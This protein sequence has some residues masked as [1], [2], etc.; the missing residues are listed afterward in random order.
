[1]QKR[2]YFEID[3]PRARLLGDLREIQEKER[4]ISDAQV[5]ALAEKYGVSRVEIEGVCTFYHFLTRKPA[6]KHTIYLNDAIISRMKG[7]DRIQ[8]A[9]EKETGARLGTTDPT[10]TFGFYSTACIGLS[11][12]EPA[13]LI[14][15]QPFTHLNVLRVREIVSQ[16]RAGIPA[17]ELCDS[18]DENVR[19]TPPGGTI[20]FAPW[21][22]GAAIR[23]LSTITRDFALEKI[24][25]SGLSGRGGAFFPTWKKW[26]ACRNYKQ[27]PRF[28]ICNADEGEPGTFK[29]RVLLQNAPGT[30]IEGMIIAAYITRASWGMIYLRGEYSW[31]AEKIQAE[32]ETF[33]NEGLL[34]REIAGMRDFSFDIRLEIGAGAYVCGE[35]TALLESMEGFRG[36]PRTKWFYPV[37]RG[38]LQ[39]PT[40]VN[41]V[42]TFAA[43]SR[44]LGLG[45]TNWLSH[46]T[47]ESRGTKLISVSGDCDLPGIYEVDYGMKV[48]E[49]LAEAKAHDPWYMQVSGPSGESITIDEKERRFAR[50][51]LLTEKDIRCGGAFM[52]FNRDRDI[53]EI[54]LNFNEFFKKE[55]CG[56]CTPCRAGN[57][58]LQR[59]LERLQHGLADR[60]DLHELHAW[61]LL[62]KKSSRCGLGKTSPN[63]I[64]T[65]LDKFSE[66]FESKYA[67]N[68][69]EQIRKFDEKS[70]V[71][72]YETFKP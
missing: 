25:E 71:A 15:F 13:A 1:M 50:H 9:F 45:L 47:D 46:G 19:Y 41:N 28:I 3:P 72:E 37:E 18:V 62:M 44:I 64:I 29:D 26:D 22:R 68:S 57:F 5:G 10:G 16:L 55:S 63:A 67:V 6:G 35:E 20:F 30:V 39:L 51:D 66:F 12:Q 48:S 38:Y 24:R 4:Y 69:N 56:V 70:A 59:K 52:I 34:G 42:E 36:E 21:D 40:I 61:G 58:I 32:I 7:Y 27:T 11:D 8:A 33:R 23:K 53:L 65:C 43:A 17:S 31:L 54:L 49:L 14:D 60:T 2:E